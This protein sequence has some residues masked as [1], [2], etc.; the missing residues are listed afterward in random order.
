MGWSKRE[1]QSQVEFLERNV[2][3]R[4]QA[5]QAE[6]DE[7]RQKHKERRRD[8]GRKR[9]NM[10]DLW[11]WWADLKSFWRR[12]ESGAVHTGRV[13][14]PKRKLGPDPLDAAL[15]ALEDRPEYVELP[16]VGL[17][18]RV[19]PASWDRIQE[20]ESLDW[21]LMRCEAA[22][23][24]VR[25]RVKESG[26]L[27]DDTPPCGECGRPMEPVELDQIGKD[28]RQQIVLLKGLIFR[29]ITAPGPEPAVQQIAGDGIVRAIVRTVKWLLGKLE[30]E[31][32]RWGSKIT[33]AEHVALLQAY[34]RVNLERMRNIPRPTTEAGDSELPSH[35]SFVFA[36][37]AHHESRPPKEIMKTR[38]LA[39]IV[40]TLS[41]EGLQVED[42]NKKLEKEMK[43]REASAKIKAGNSGRRR[44]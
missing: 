44:G 1:L 32:V 15:K 22:R 2:V 12:E 9:A 27:P 37:Q 6:I 42:R 7:L 11:R 16:S 3:R 28:I 35:W 34:H 21:W 8:Q 31:P 38:S 13:G 5:T 18:V 19:T 29:Q 40:A 17:F 25:D 41:L 20:I 24:L 39:A 23:W 36:H 10:E 14:A 26:R 30:L 43:A 33:P 4:G